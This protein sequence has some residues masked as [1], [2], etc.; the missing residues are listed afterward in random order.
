MVRTLLIATC[1]AFLGSVAK[2]HEFWIDP[3]DHQ[4][5]FGDKVQADLRVGEAYEGGRQSYLP[6]NFRRFDY[7]LQG[8][9]LPVEGRI[10]DRPAMQVTPEAEGLLVAVHVTTDSHITWTTWDRFASFLTHKDL[11]WGL[12]AHAD[13]G[14]PREDVRERYS[15]YAK[16][17]IAV[18]D[19]AGSDSEVGLETEI[20]A[21]EN[22]FTDNMA[23]GL[24][25]RALYRQAPMQN[26]QIEVFQKAPD[27]SVDVTLHRTND[28]GEATIPV[29]PGHR[30]QLDTVVLRPLDMAEPGD[31]SWET[32]WANMTLE[33]PE[34]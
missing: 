15:R 32:L 22:P 20:V 2:G 28:A 1:M 7:V 8:Q 17:L 5:S 30:Y 29:K 23:D 33:V 14:L 31:A 10:G 19:G 3:L 16:S 12:E 6:R 13:R 26:V 11:T 18:G 34:N 4:V 21:L 25:I 27:G 24:D 9:T